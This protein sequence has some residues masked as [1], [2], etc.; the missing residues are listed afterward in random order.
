MPVISLALCSVI[1]LLDWEVNEQLILLFAVKIHFHFTD[2]KTENS[3]MEPNESDQMNQAF[4]KYLC[5]VQQRFHE[6]IFCNRFQSLA[7]GAQYDDV[8]KAL[9]IKTDTNNIQ[10]DFK[11]SLDYCINVLLEDLKSHGTMIT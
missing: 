5:A 7:K 4:D 6:K 11:Q 1:I 10:D 9:Q 8:L 2:D 3:H